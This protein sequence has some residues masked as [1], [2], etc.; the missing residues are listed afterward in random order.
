MADAVAEV[1]PH[2]PRAVVLDE[3]RRTWSVEHTV[4]NL[5]EEGV[6]S[7]HSHLAPTPS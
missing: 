7:S 6:Y 4:N 3:L 2:V 5:L 1:V